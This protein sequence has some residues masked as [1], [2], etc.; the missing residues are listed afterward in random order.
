MCMSGVGNEHAAA[1]DDPIPT[2]TSRPRQRL[3]QTR[4]HPINRARGELER[5]PQLAEA[6]LTPELEQSISEMGGSIRTWKEPQLQQPPQ[7]QRTSSDCQVRMWGARDKA[8]A[9]F[10]RR[11][12]LRCA[13]ASGPC[14]LKTGGALFVGSMIPSSKG[15]SSR[16]QEKVSVTSMR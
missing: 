14:E 9:N 7:A 10:L 8:C 11:P 2:V 6:L 15:S 4:A 16:L 3:P 5:K 1:S 13:G 12:C